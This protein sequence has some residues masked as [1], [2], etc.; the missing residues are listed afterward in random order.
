LKVKL[1]KTLG[2]AAQ[3]RL[4]CY[5]IFLLKTDGVPLVH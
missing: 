5:L 2:F 4:K 3:R 1:L